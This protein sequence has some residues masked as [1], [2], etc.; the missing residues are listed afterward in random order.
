[1]NTPS[2]DRRRS[3]YCLPRE[4][5]RTYL[6]FASQLIQ[7]LNVK[8]GGWGVTNTL[9]VALVRLK[10]VFVGAPSTRAGRVTGVVE[11]AATQL[12]D[13]AV[14]AKLLARAQDRHAWGVS[15]TP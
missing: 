9:G 15:A 2:A 6:V 10:I 4:E 12:R 7:L 14:Y 8:D 11:R 3:M 5:I 1:M 13:A